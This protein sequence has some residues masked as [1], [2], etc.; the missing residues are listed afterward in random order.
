MQLPITKAPVRHQA[1]VGQV[2]VIDFVLLEQIE[3]SIDVHLDLLKSSDLG[4]VRLPCCGS[5]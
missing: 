1:V 3:D 2:E 5:I 4:T